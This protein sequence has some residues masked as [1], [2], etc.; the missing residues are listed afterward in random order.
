MA[1]QNNYSHFA[2]NDGAT[3]KRS[4]SRRVAV[5]GGSV[6]AAGLVAAGAGAGIAYGQAGSL[7]SDIKSDAQTLMKTVNSL[8]DA[9]KDTDFTEALSYSE[10]LKPQISNLSAILNNP[11]VSIVG[12][13]TQ[14]GTDIQIVRTL[15]STL[16][17]VNDGAI[18][19]LLTV[20]SEYRLD[21]LIWKIDGGVQVDIDGIQK[22]VDALDDAIPHIL[23]CSNALDG[24]GTSSMDQINTAVDKVK[25]AFGKY[26][27]LL[28]SAQEILPYVPGLFGA[29]GTMTYLVVAQGNSELHSTGGFPGAMGISTFENGVFQLG[30]FAGYAAILPPQWDNPIPITQEENDLFG[31]ALGYSVGDMGRDP[32]FSRVAVLW[33]SSCQQENGFTPNSVV[34]LDPVFLQKLVALSGKSIA[35][36]DGTV[37]DGTNCAQMLLSQVYWDYMGDKVGADAYFTEAANGAFDAVCSSLGDISFTDLLKLIEDALDDR[38]LNVWF[39]D[40]GLQEQLVKLDYDNGLNRDETKPA[41]GLYLSDNTWAKIE[42]YLD[43]SIVEGESY[44]ADG[45]TCVPVS[46]TLTNSMTYDEVYAANGSGYI[47]GTNEDMKRQDG[48][49]VMSLYLYPP[50]GGSIEDLYCSGGDLSDYMP[51]FAVLPHE[52]FQVT[53]CVVKL[54]PGESMTF[55]CVVRCSPNAQEDLKI[56]HTPLCRDI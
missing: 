17:D 49:M 23:S 37:I 14:Y 9:I 48:D 15:L 7:I 3:K 53:T 24:V 18:Y 11:I 32:D 25:T 34:A 50:A 46:F 29:N 41:L 28:G 42:W 10:E 21:N 40:A 45:A 26:S 27:G 13:F 52:G 54:L 19:P 56:D 4:V 47:L 43:A 55:S 31:E 38:R 36:S 44:L 39:S 5:V 12:S 22:M 8:I 6:V 30:D 33:A 35:M 1:S 16:E 2:P 51:G 20:M